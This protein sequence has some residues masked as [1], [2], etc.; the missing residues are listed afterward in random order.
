MKIRYGVGALLCI[1]NLLEEADDAG[2]GFLGLLLGHDR[3]R[4]GGDEGLTIFSV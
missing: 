4:V 3:V 2:R 1:G